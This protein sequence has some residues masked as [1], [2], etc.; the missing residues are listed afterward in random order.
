VAHPKASDEVGAAH[1]G[2]EVIC[3]NEVDL[4]GELAFLK[5]LESALG[6][7][8]GDDKVTGSLEDGLAGG[9]L[10]SI[11]INQKDRWRHWLC[12]HLLW[13]GLAEALFR[14]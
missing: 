3:D 14:V 7:K 8:G 1:P 9:S 4:G 10:D 2:H 11:V 6:A 13:P 5:L 12:C